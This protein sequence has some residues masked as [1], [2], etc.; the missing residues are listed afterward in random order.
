MKHLKDHFVVDGLVYSYMQHNEDTTAETVGELTRATVSPST[1]VPSLELHLL[2][3]LQLHHDSA[4]LPFN[5]RLR[6][7]TM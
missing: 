7:A 1:L 3:D 6:R 2:V 4:S 5:A